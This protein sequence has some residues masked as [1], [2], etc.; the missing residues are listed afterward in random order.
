MRV[1]KSDSLGVGLL[2][3]FLCSHMELDTYDL[4]S[5]VC[6]ELLRL[7]R[8]LEDVQCYGGY[9][10]FGRGIPSALWSI[11]RT[12]KGYHKHFGYYPHSTNGIPPHY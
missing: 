8:T 6:A 2:F 4:H 12:V 1:L 3:R 11:F 7:F 5:D 10:T 9:H